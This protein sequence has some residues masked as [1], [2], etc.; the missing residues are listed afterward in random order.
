MESNTYKGDIKIARTELKDAYR[1]YRREVK[2][3]HLLRRQKAIKDEL[4][5]MGVW[6]KQIPITVIET[7]PQ[8]IKVRIA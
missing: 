6:S 8:K 4:A 2:K 3:L 1:K 5:S 7:K